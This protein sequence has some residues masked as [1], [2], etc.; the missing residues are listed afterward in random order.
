MRH[1]EPRP[2]D[3]EDRLRRALHAQLDGAEP[4][5]P[6]ASVRAP[7]ARR[8]TRIPFGLVAAAASVVVV[9]ALVGSRL[10]WAVGHPGAAG[11]GTAAAS[12]SVLADT[13]PAPVPPGLPGAVAP[14]PSGGIGTGTASQQTPS[15][16]PAATSAGPAVVQPSIRVE[17]PPRPA[18]PP[19]ASRPT[20]TATPATQIAG[21]VV[22]TLAQGG[23]TFDL[24]VGQHLEL[25]LGTSYQWSI[26][27][28][29]SGVLAAVTAR[30]PPGVQGLWVAERA[31]TASILAIGNPPCLQAKPPC[32]MPS[33]EFGI[34]VIVR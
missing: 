34:T 4:A 25:Q 3:T 16:R 31:G 6:P 19:P 17:P 7:G 2:D 23:G 30:V 18:T 24:A 29:A 33:R 10:P 11:T 5:A 32:G 12:P 26:S 1:D 22:V 9:A 15:S 27:V 14:V 28:T 21:T 8:A 20:P 13:F